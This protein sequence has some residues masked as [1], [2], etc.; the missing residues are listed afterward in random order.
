MTKKAASQ[1]QSLD[2]VGGT[3]YGNYS[4]KI[5]QKIA[6]TKGFVKHLGL[7]IKTPGGPHCRSKYTLCQRTILN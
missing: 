6:Y 4:S 3:L 2:R 5:T 1:T 7:P